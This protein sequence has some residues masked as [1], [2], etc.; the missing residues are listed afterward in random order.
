MRLRPDWDILLVER[1]DEDKHAVYHRMCGEGISA[2]GMK[3]LDHDASPHIVHK[4]SKAVERWPGGITVSS[5]IDGY[6]IDRPGLLR[7]IREDAVRRGATYLTGNV[8]KISQG[9]EAE[10]FLED[11]TSHSGRW[12]I[13][14]DGARSKVRGELFSS[15]PRHMIWADQYVIDEAMDRDVIEFVYDQKYAG[16]YLWRFPS[17]NK[18][19]M[20]FPKGT[21][22]APKGALETHRRAIPVGEVPK[23]VKGRVALVGD[24]GGLVNPITFGGIRIAFATGRMAAEAAVMEDLSRYQRDWRSSRYVHPSFWTGY[25]QLCAMTNEQLEDAMAPFRNGYTR[26]SE[27]KAMLAKRQYRDVYR[28]F[29]LSMEMG[30]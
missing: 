10:I 20:G 25:E 17:G 12:L 28:S 22:E 18:T 26:V 2:A 29:A 24:A 3:E 30:W 7:S 23:L 27:L 9:R 15:E 16:G 19:R 8:A 5:P 14:A 11:G 6:I 13:A 21:D 1:L 4:I